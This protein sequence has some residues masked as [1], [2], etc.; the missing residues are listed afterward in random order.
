MLIEGFMRRCYDLRVV[1]QTEIIIGAK[2]EYFL[3]TLNFDFD[4]LR[5]CDYTFSLIQ[6]SS[7]DFLQRFGQAIQ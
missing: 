4:T 2:I 1:R 5:G 3:T 7:T 6:T